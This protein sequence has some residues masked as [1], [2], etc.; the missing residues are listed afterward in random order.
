MG[1]NIYTSYWQQVLPS[2]IEQFKQGSTIAKATVN[3]LAALGNR[4][5]YYANF[6]INKS[7]LENSNNAYAQ[8]RDLYSVL[9]EDAYFKE[10]LANSFIQVTISKDLQLTMEILITN[11]PAFFT[12]A[13]FVALQQFNGVVKQDSNTTHQQTYDTLKQTYDK[14]EYWNKQVQAQLFPNGATKLVKKPTNQA[15]KFEEYQWGK[16]YPTQELLNQKILAYTLT[17]DA[18]NRFIVKI[19]TVGLSDSDAKRKKYF[20][21]R[22]DYNNSSIVKIIPKQQVLDKSWKYL[23]NLSVNDILA[24]QPHFITLND[25]LNNTQ[26]EK[27]TQQTSNMPLNTILYGPPGTGKTYN[28]I[29]KALEILGYD[30]ANKDRK[31]IKEEFDKSVAEKQIVFTTFHQSMSY[32]DFIEGIKPKT[33]DGK[34]LYE[35]ED[36]IFKKIC[37]KAITVKG[38]FE[39]ILDKFKQDV[40]EQDGKPPITINAASTSFDV[41][42]R[43][44]NVFYA[45]PH[46]S[47]KDNAWYPVNIN[48]IRRGFETND[49]KELY[50]PTYIREILNYW[51]KKYGLQKKEDE[52]ASIKPY[53]IIIDEINRGNI[54]QIF[55]EL[56]T[57]IEDD[58]RL[59]KPEAISIT[60]PYSKESFAVPSNLY[61]IGTMNTADRSVEALDTALRRRFVF[62][63]M[64]PKPELIQEVFENEFLNVLAANH[65]LSWE[66]PKWKAIEKEYIEL[67]PQEVYAAFSVI[68]Q[69]DND[70]DDKLAEYKKVWENTNL[71]LKTVDV[72]N[73][74][75]QRITLLLSRDHLIGHSYFIGKYTWAA[76]QQ[77]F[78]KNILPLLQ[79]YFYGDYGKIGLVLGQGFVEIVSEGNENSKSPFARFGNYETAPF[80]EK[81]KYILK[82]VGNMKV[83]DFKAAIN[84]LLEGA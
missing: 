27:T 50:N 68:K 32:E 40:S 80:L 17:I 9:K 26:E 76:L 34:V 43:G 71:K 54:S 83:E 6:T 30:I 72:L 16:I 33:V 60:L 22:G 67:L 15:N 3:G 45:K 18:Y 35:V 81:P 29:N 58:K 14:V 44:T 7:I 63:E 82:D 11:A 24:L 12:E 52:Q 46:S 59:G 19:D 84:T 28:T 75:N 66:D 5:S 51:I 57:L 4:Q 53:V 65:Q 10:N 69:L 74:I 21:Y 41:I 48:N 70:F 56:I 13:D 23:I 73:T 36:G 78:H 42:Y 25:L 64:M 62:E 77:S 1:E 49:Y 38:N 2:L 55:G 61:I 20:E 31:T 79:E 47:T 39:S 37:N 8:G